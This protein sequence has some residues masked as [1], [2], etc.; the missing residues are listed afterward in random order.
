MRDK[1]LEAAGFTFSKFG[2][3]KTSMEDIA[4][5]A[6]KS[7]GSLY[8]HFGS[9]ELLFEAVVF[10]ELKRLT[11]ALKPI[12]DKTDLDSRQVLKLYMLKRME[13]LRNAP[14][15]QE[16]LRPSFYEHYT[17]LDQI[18]TQITEWE[19]MQISKLLKQ[20]L[21][22]EELEL[23][24]DITVYAQVLVMLLQGLEPNFYL[25]GEYDRLES[26]FDNLI[27]IITKGISK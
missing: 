3:Y 9:K 10:E 19:V 18:K 4:E 25:K 24:G 16:T 15:Y 2:Y 22:K 11:N 27:Q 13:V 5:K 8:Y 1:L 23:P 26:Y 20:G 14:N 12:F 6:Q 17:F 7:K 21:M